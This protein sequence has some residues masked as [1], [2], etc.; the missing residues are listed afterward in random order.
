MLRD[1]ATLGY[2]GISEREIMVIQSIFRMTERFH[3]AFEL[4]REN[5]RRVPDVLVVD[6]DSAAALSFWQEFSRK[7]NPS[8]V[9]IFISSSVKEK[10]GEHHISRPLVLRKLMEV[11]DSIIDSYSSTTGSNI[12]ASAEALSST[13]GLRILV[14]DDSLPVRTYMHQKISELCKGRVTIDFAEDGEAAT[15]QVSKHNHDLVFLDVM[16]PGMDGYKTCKWI[17]ANKPT[18][19]ALLTSRSSPFDKVRGTMSGCDNYLV[20]PPQ[21]SDLMR[22]IAERVQSLESDGLI[23]AGW[24]EAASM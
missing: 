23:P 13:R 9:P 1:K 3:A 7:V 21:D 5:E 19:V 18:Y 8:A 10:S 16:M 6:H 14:V 4:P 11:L 22:I 24:L 15:V 2:I 17:K 12:S 20:K